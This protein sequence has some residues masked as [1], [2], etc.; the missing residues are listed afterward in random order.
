MTHRSND[1]KLAG[2]AAAG[3]AV[4][5]F[6]GPMGAAIGAVAGGAAVQMSRSST[7]KRSMAIKAKRARSKVS[8]KNQSG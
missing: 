5:S 1:M 3:A 6:L 2:G 4:G 7:G 8:K